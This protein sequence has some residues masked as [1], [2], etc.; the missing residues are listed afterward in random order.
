MEKGIFDG[1]EKKE[2]EPKIIRAKNDTLAY[3]DAYQIF[4]ITIKVNDFTEKQ[5]QRLL[6]KILCPNRKGKE[7]VFGMA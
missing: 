6:C 1:T 2:K 3:L 5:R 4:C 7:G